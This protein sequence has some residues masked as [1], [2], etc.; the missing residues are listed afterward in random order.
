MATVPRIYLITSKGNVG[1]IT[2]KNGQVIAIYDSD[3]I[4]YDVPSDGTSE[5][6][7][8]RR[9]VS[10]I[11]IV[12]TLPVS[13]ETD[14]LYVHSNILKIWDGTTWINVGNYSADTNV[15]STASDGKFYL[16]GTSD[17]TSSN[18]T[19][20]KNA[21]VYVDDGV[22][23]GSFSGN[24]TTATT[25]TKAINDNASTPKPITGYV[26]NVTGSGSIITVTKGDGTTSS[27][28]IPNTTYDLFSASSK[29]LVDKTAVVVVSDSTNLILTGSGWMNKANVSVGSATTATTA[30]TATSA[31]TATTATS[32]TSAT[33]DGSNNTITSTY[34]KNVA[35]ND[36]TGVFTVT[37]GDNTT[38][39]PAPTIPTVSSSK[40]G[41]APAA[42]GAGETLKF[43]KGDGTWSTP[44]VPNYDGTTAGSVP[45]AASGQSAYYLRGDATWGGT[46][47]T[48]SVGLVP[49]PASSSD[50]G[51]LLQY[52]STL[53]YG[54]GGGK[55]VNPSVAT[56]TTNTAGTSSDTSH[57]LF[58]VG[59]QSQSADSDEGTQ[60]YTNANFYIE[61]GK[62]HQSGVDVVD[63]SSSQALTNKTYN[64]YTLAAACAKAVDTTVT[65]SSTNLPTSQAVCN[66][67][68]T[69]VNPNINLKADAA[70]IA[71]V[72]AATATYNI[73]DYCTYWDISDNTYK[74]YKCNTTISTAETWDDTHWDEVVGLAGKDTTYSLTERK[75]GT[76]IDGSDIYEATYSSQ[77]WF[78]STATAI[79][80][81]ATLS[82]SVVCDLEV[83]STIST[84]GSATHIFKSSSDSCYIDSTKK[85]MAKQSLQATQ[86][87]STIQTYI[88]IKYTK[89]A[90]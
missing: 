54:A 46:F 56:N 33:K 62:L 42:S 57:K 65:S 45:P 76:W 64:S 28:T 3:E 74:L 88:T 26:N 32:A 25:A 14:I 51:K 72:Y 20:L 11:Q 48:T 47:T 61:N 80:D 87:S 29:G 84:S 53:N 63:V 35:Y 52:D 21:D 13:P 49:I 73:G 43:L 78:G 36:S 17:A 85:V 23:Y 1:N 58:L 81:L 22:I 82:Y 8:V 37:K 6:E 77:T 55:W 31:T 4:Y 19:L 68:T 86:G 41:L 50:N 39:S 44:S 69:N 27:I 38:I 83:I 10:G 67:I 66:Y 60:T 90:S 59:S 5:G 16:V 79:L 12:D 15:S 30:T 2:P 71:P 70:M 40:P 89:P 34:I 7:P 9:K 24:A 18:G 75:I